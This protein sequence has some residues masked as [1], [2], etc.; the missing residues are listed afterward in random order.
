MAGT[1]RDSIMKKDFKRP[2][3]NSE[4]VNGTDLY[5]KVLIE[6]ARSRYDNDKKNVGWQNRNMTFLLS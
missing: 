6:V 1:I 4:T 2:K 5:R 3:S